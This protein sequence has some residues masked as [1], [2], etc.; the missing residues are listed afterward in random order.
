MNAHRP[1]RVVY[2][3]RDLDGE[4]AT[5]LASAGR[6]EREEVAALIARLGWELVDI[7]DAL[8][9]GM[10]RRETWRST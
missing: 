2:I 4:W 9:P 6:K 10:L 1:G 7:T 5:V 3:C 8:T